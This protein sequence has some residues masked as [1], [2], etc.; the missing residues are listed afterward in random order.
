MKTIRETGTIAISGWLVLALVIGAIIYGAYNFPDLIDMWR[1]TG[2]EGTP[3][4]LII[5]FV[6]FIFVIL[7]SFVINNPNESRVL[8]FFGRYIGTLRGT[9]FYWVIP[10]TSRQVISRRVV[11]LNTKT[12]KVND[13]RG[14]PIEIG[15]V[16]VWN[17]EDSAKAALNV[18][19]Y[20][21]FVAVQS[22]TAVR[23][24]AS[25]LPY[26]S[27]DG[28]ESLRGSPDKVSEDLKTEL[29]ARVEVAGVVVNEARLSHL[30]YAPEIASAMLRR[31]QA[32]AVVSAR[33]IITENA[34]KMVETALEQIAGTGKI[35]L[36]EE[37]KGKLVSNLLVA[38]VAERDAQ[39]I[40]DL[41]P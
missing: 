19:N 24:L 25:R 7:P 29:Q 30:A 16:I 1:A 32:Q 41:N 26:D 23:T 9:G 2:F 12:I 27:E 6:V 31:Q 35:K 3:V 38:L 34:V 8:L 18:D 39:P 14:N 4:P 37:A 10:F 17:V 28:D 15:A 5:A 21:D 33:R 11:S 36:S 40:I 22:E 13:L 20:H